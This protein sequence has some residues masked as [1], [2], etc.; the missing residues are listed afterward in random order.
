MRLIAPSEKFGGDV[1]FDAV[2]S[3]EEIAWDYG[4]DVYPPGK[5]FLL[6][7]YEDMFCYKLDGKNIKIENAA[8]APAQAIVAIRSCDVS[9]VRFQEK[10]YVNQIVDPYFKAKLDNTVLFSLVCNTPPKKECFCIC[11]DAGPYLSSAYDVQLTDLGDRFLYEIGSEKGAAAT[12]PLSKMLSDAGDGD[13]AERR[14]IELQADSLFQTTAFFAKAIN[15]ISSDE[16]PTRFGRSLARRASG[17]PPARTSAPSARAT[18]W[19]I[20]PRPTDRS[21][22]AGRGTRASSP[23]SPERPAGTTRG[24][25]S[26]KRV[27]R[28]FYHKASYQYVQRDGTHGCVGCGRCC[29]RVPD[30]ARRPQ[31]AEAHQK[32]DAQASQSARE[33]RGGIDHGCHREQTGKD[34]G[35]NGRHGRRALH[36]QDRDNRRHHR[37]D[38]DTKTFRLVF[39]DKEYAKSFSWEPGSSSK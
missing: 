34:V 36:P 26:A 6:P 23:G 12:E 27:K 25:R 19:T 18:P 14:K 16:V 38:A 37:R 3:P 1:V 4:H 24:L 28:R 7:H 39:E 8:A 29:Q 21:R 2:E 15:Y 11:C 30:E 5:R 32:I 10:F 13:L 35:R 9:A 22:D 33:G 20:V 17:A 31:R